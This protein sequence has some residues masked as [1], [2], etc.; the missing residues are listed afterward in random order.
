MKQVI[1]YILEKI[2]SQT[3]GHVC[4]IDLQKA[5]D[6]LDYQILIQK[7]EKYGY[8]GL[9]LEIMKSYLSDRRQ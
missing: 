1:E 9:V 7:H 2:D 5:F 3:N 4:F 6:T 8:R